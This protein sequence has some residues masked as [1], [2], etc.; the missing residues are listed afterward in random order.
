M[1]LA[2]LQQILRAADPAA[3]LVSQRVLERVIQE[4]CKLPNLFWAVP[5][6]ASYVVDRKVLFTHVDQE[7]LDL[8]ADQL[9]LPTFILLARPSSEELGAAD[10]ETILLKYWQRLFHAKIHAFLESRYVAG[11]LTIADIRDRI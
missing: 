3:V 6:R 5:H 8:Q 7:E 10:R 11:Q 9:L 4:V 2:E 1:K